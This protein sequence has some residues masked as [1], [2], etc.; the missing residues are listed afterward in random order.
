MLVG[1]NLINVSNKKSL[2]TK[3]LSLHCKRYW[4]AVMSFLLIKKVILLFYGKYFNI[5]YYFLINI[6]IY[7]LNTKYNS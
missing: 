3:N 4:K 7:T 1:R 6:P 5:I 2:E